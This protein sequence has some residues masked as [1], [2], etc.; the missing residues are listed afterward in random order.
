MA[1][2]SVSHLCNLIKSTPPTALI[3]LFNQQHLNPY[4]NFYYPG[5]FL[6]TCTDN[7]SKQRKIYR[8]EN[9]IPPTISSNHCPVHPII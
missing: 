9:L 2:I 3:N 4:L 1:L 5:F 7:Q 8:Y 6:K